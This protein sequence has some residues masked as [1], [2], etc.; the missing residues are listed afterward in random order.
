MF[1]WKLFRRLTNYW[2]AIDNPVFARETQRAPLWQHVASRM[3]QSSGLLVVLTG[4]LCYLSTVIAYYA[5]TLL[6]LLVPL[7]ILWTLLL[8]LTMAPV[9]VREREEQTWQTL[10]TTPM[11]LDSIMLG[12]AAGALWWLRHLMRALIGLTLIGAIA[13]GIG[14]LVFVSFEDEM[15]STLPVPLICGLTVALP[16]VS[17]TLFLVDRAQQMMLAALCGLAISAQSRTVRLAAP[18]AVTIALLVT[19]LDMAVGLLVLTQLEQITTPLHELGLLLLLF[20]PAV[21]Y[22]AE[23]P[24]WVAVGVALLTLLAREGAI[25]LGWQWTL[26]AARQP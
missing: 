26:R 21:V 23:L 1:S 22:L 3:A 18:L 13:V 24:F 5:Q 17:S 9:V 4:V 2:A 6:V 16:M 25:W 14:S 19:A 12:K 20:G 10:R 11:E 8:S 7:I 15:L